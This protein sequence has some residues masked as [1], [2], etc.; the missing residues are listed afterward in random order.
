MYKTLIVYLLMSNPPIKKVRARTIY[1]N[2]WLTLE[3][4]DVEVRASGHRFSYSFL[5]MAPSVMVV[6]VTRERKVCW[7]DSTATRVESTPLSCLAAEVGDSNRPTYA[8]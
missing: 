6:A 5:A 7:F 4:H 8:S 1:H 3:Q 2:R